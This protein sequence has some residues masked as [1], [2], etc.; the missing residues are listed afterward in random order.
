MNTLRNWPGLLCSIGGAIVVACIFK[1]WVTIRDGIGIGLTFAEL[2]DV[3]E[4]GIDAMPVT[5][6]FVV[7]LMLGIAC[8]ASVKLPGMVVWLLSVAGLG[9]TIGSLVYLTSAVDALHL[10]HWEHKIRVHPYPGSFIAC[11][12][13]FAM[14]MIQTT[15]GLAEKVTAAK[16]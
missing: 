9:V 13:F 7:I 3:P 15:N 6:L 8:I 11:C 4:Y 10:E 1:S 2:R 5:F 12:C 16:Q 14:V